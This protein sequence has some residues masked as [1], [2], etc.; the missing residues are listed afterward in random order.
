M[1]I[2]QASI[3][4][5]KMRYKIIAEAIKSID[6]N[7]KKYLKGADTYIYTQSIGTI[8][9]TEMELHLL[10]AFGMKTLITNNTEALNLKHFQEGSIH[11][12]VPHMIKNK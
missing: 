12:I 8:V 6:H 5:R 2:G 3:D 11:I 1:I 9:L 4:S 10:S 7:K